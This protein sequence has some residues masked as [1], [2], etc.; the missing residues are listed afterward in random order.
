MTK[1]NK[2]AVVPK[3]DVLTAQDINDA[4][5]ETKMTFSDIVEIAATDMYQEVVNAIKQTQIDA[6]SLSEEYDNTYKKEKEEALALYKKTTGR[7]GSTFLTAKGIRDSQDQDDDVRYAVLSARNFVEIEGLRRSS[8]YQMYFPKKGSK[9]I[10]IFQVD[11][12]DQK[13]SEI[14]LKSKGKNISV[15][16]SE[17]YSARM[18]YPV[19]TKDLSDL[20]KRIN[21]HNEKVNG[22]LRSFNTDTVTVEK[23]IREARTKVNRKILSSQPEEFKKKLRGVFKINI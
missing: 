1:S 2:L 23:F 9:T 16:F 10:H 7:D 21:E 5:F 20:Y 22:F 17:T 19:K 3:N 15:T 14:T 8:G 4:G 11:G 18:E 6:E 12:V 13:K